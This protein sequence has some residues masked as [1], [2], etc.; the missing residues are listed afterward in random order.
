MTY[1]TQY[2]NSTNYNKINTFSDSPL[3][4]MGDRIAI[5]SRAVL[6]QKINLDWNRIPE[7][8]LIDVDE[9]KW[10]GVCTLVVSLSDAIIYTTMLECGDPDS[11]GTCIDIILNQM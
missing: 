1:L 6:F 8:L 11:C 10:Y 3:Y 5:R 9:S 4:H 2:F 7:R